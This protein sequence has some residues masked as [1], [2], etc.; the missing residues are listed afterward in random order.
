MKREGVMTKQEVLDMLDQDIKDTD[1]K[2]NY[3]QRELRLYVMRLEILHQKREELCEE[4]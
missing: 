2:I 3:H 1:W 4:K